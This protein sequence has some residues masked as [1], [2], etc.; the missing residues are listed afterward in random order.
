TG[1]NGTFTAGNLKAGTYL[2]S[3]APGACLSGV[4]QQSA[5]LGPNKS[6]SFSV[7]PKTNTLTGEVTNSKTGA[8]IA[9]VVI[10]EN[11]GAGTTTSTTDGSGSYTF[12]HGCSN[13]ANATATVTVP[14]NYVAISS[15]TV[16][17][18]DNSND[19]AN[20]TLQPFSVLSGTVF[21]DI[22]D[23]GTLN[24]GDNGYQGIT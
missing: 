21:N 8:G 23:S 1:F 17:F 7:L 20:F 4:T 12:S 6:V 10:T 15:T 13:F 16:G 3:I 22:N 19:T 18:S 24:S 2:V 14:A 9:N 11:S 5:I